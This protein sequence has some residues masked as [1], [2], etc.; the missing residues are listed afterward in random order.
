VTAEW[1]P[2][3]SNQRAKFYRLTPAGRKQL[4]S[5]QDRWEQMVNAIA[6]VMSPEY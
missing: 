6:G 2:T 4:V 1:K 3:E 5:E